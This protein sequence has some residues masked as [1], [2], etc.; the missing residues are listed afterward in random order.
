MQSKDDF[1][2]VIGHELRTPLN[3]II[4]LSNA[5]ARGAGGGA[6]FAWSK[7]SDL[8][9]KKRKGCVILRGCG[10]CLA[11]GSVLCCEGEG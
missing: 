8:S 4:Q 2:S 9:C 1:I 10:L 3:A 6:V 7:G 11:Q 5:M